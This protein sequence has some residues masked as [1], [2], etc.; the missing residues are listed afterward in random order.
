MESLRGQLLVAGP[1]LEDPNFRRTVVLVAEHGEGGA[2]G[3]ILNRPSHTVV[4]EAAPELG[5]VAEPDD[6]IFEGGPVQPTAV[7]VLAEF[8]APSEAAAVVLE[9]IGFLAAES[10]LGDAAG[11]TRRSRVF[12][13]FAGWG[14]GQLESELERDDWIVTPARREEIFSSDPAGLWPAV[15]EGRGGQYALLAR[16]PEDP[17]VN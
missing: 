4:E 9:D 14:P 16:M 10:D 3:L 17:R 13:G 6:I 15:L 11:V 5:E 12:A 1:Q 7:V 8:D 2:M